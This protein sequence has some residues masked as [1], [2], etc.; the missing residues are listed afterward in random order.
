[1]L[2]EKY[3]QQIVIKTATVCIAVQQ[4]IIP[5]TVFIPQ[6]GKSI[7]ERKQQEQSTN[8]SKLW[9]NITIAI[10]W[11][12]SGKSERN[13]PKDRKVGTQKSTIITFHGHGKK[14]KQEAWKWSASKV[15]RHQPMGRRREIKT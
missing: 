2:K 9:K 7:N 13:K 11:R 8:S 10:E 3:I 6:R 1:M 12:N 15:D 4:K 5:A 14:A